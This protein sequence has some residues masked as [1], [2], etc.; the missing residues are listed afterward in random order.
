[1]KPMSKKQNPPA[2]SYLAINPI[3]VVLLLAIASAGAHFTV[4][5]DDTPG[6][7][8]LKYEAP[9][10]LTANICD[11][12]GTNLLFKFKRTATRSGT[13]LSVLREF[14]APDGILA[15]RETVVY[16]GDKLVSY[17]LDELQIGASGSAKILRDPKSP[18]AEKIEFSYQVSGG[19]VEKTIESLRADT[20]NG[21]LLGPFLAEHWADLLK[22]R[23]VKCRY[24]VVPR[25]ETVGFTFSKQEETTWQGKPVVVIRMVPTSMIISLIV[26]PVFFT[27]EKN[28]QHRVLQYTGR[29]TPKLKSKTGW[30]DLDA[31]TVFDWK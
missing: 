30:K 13:N 8:P 1:M 21:D 31:V 29:T 11:A 17:A 22:G 3:G 9:V 15:A 18:A 27:M 19:K 25:K 23:E 2:S 16:Q 14:T 7:P 24:L 28:G 20:L 5:A 10:S 4:W 6:A 12:T 26:D